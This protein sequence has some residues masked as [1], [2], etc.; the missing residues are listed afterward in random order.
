MSYKII[1]IVLLICCTQQIFSENDA[2]RA[3]KEFK[4]KSDPNV[5]DKDINPKLGQNS[6]VNVGITLYVISSK[7]NPID[8]SVTTNMYF[9][10]K[11]SDPRLQHS[12]PSVK[13]VGSQSFIDRVWIPDTFLPN[14]DSITTVSI[15]T[16]TSFAMIESNGTVF[17]SHKFQVT[18]R[19]LLENT[20]LVCP[21]E[22]ESYGYSMK[23]VDF[24][25]AKGDQSAGITTDIET[26]GGYKFSGK[27]IDKKVEKL[28]SGN[29]AR[30]IFTMKFERDT[31]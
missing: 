15:P 17:I 19:C 12:Y 7:I 26:I 5:Y 28:S 16:P 8:K 21:I 6:S 23:D 24:E 29:Y 3:V 2:I 30:L 1:S 9:R 4:A 18:S 10:Q 11:W 14:A 25:W 13:V 31:I 20:S 27:T 22:I